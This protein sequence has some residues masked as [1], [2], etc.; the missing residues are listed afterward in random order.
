MREDLKVAIVC[1]WLTGIGG[2]ERVVLQIHKLFPSAPI[3]TSQY[4]PQKIDWFKKA[5]VRTLWTQK[6]PSSIKKFLPPL[7]AIAFRQLNLSNYDLVISSSGA[8][9]KA[10]RTGKNTIHICYCHAPTHYYWMRYDDYLKD[11]GFG[12]LDWLARL[13]LR[14]FVWPLRWLDY[15]AAQKPD[16]LIANSTFTKEQI[17]KYYER[18]S[19]VIY[20]PVDIDRFKNNIPWNKKN[21]FVIVGRQTPYKKVNLAVN[22]ATELGIDLTVIGDG[23]DHKMLV[24]SAGP[25][26]KFITNA[27]DREVANYVARSKA[28]I[29]PNIDDFGISAV[30]SLAA[31]TPVIAYRGGG[32]LDYITDKNG[33]FFNED[34]VTSII[35]TIVRLL[36]ISFNT[37]LIEESIKKFNDAEFINNLQGYINRVMKQ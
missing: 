27:N 23:P 17:K 18:D 8:E 35:K 10:V 28:F 12:Q 30:E 11:P 2:A 32:A 15:K 37:K 6:L 25:S 21:G 4:D 5:D 1:D 22:A 9:A 3:Y 29:F 34:T 24:K 36:N 7:R 14:F 16:Y 31:G 13:A 26:V 19:E 20:P 33:L